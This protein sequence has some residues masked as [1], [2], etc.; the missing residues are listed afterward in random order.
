ME[1]M[2]AVTFRAIPENLMRQAKAAAALKGVT[3]RQ[4]VIDAITLALSQAELPGARKRKP[5]Q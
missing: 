5:R 3:L 1:S 4:F 2:K